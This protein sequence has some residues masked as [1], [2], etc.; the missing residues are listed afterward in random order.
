M[1]SVALLHLFFLSLI[2]GQDSVGQQDLKTTEAH[3]WLG[4]YEIIISQQKRLNPD[5]LTQEQ[6]DAG[7]KP[8]WCSA[9]FT[10]VQ[11][12]K[13]IDGRDFN[14]IFP[15]GWHFGI[16]LP[17]KQESAKHFILLKYGDYNSRIFV[18][19]D[20][21]K[22]F[23]L[24]GDSYRIFLDRYL[25]VRGGLADDSPAFSIF[26]LYENKLLTLDWGDPIKVTHSP[27][28][29]GNATFLKLYESTT[30][31]FASLD[32]VKD[33][34]LETIGHTNYFYRIDLVTGKVE[35]AV[36]IENKHRE[37]VIDYSNIDMSTDCECIK[38]A[39]Y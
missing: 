8:L 7:I 9:H 14:D 37:F 38:R 36:F 24:G 20:E 16:H 34:G 1:K 17:I 12:G 11:N 22:L 35:D 23:T 3:Y 27:P 5:K 2:A 33:Y 15:V 32:I 30:E 21:G 19:T 4:N 31:L 25:V 18:F 29:N 26:D 28:V 6:V 39:D 10:I 13:F